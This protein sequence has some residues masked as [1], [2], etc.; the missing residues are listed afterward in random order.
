METKQPVWKLTGHIGDRDVISYGGGFIYEDTTGV[1][2]PEVAY[3]EPASN[4]DWRKKDS[5]AICTIYRFCL[6]RDGTKEWWF[7][8]LDKISSFTGESLESLEHVARVGRL[9]EVALLY[10]DLVSY[11]GAFEFDSYP[12]QLKE[13]DAR[14]KYAA[15]LKAVS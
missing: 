13:K 6:E 4:A 7:K 15:E 14:A 3:F 1:Y 8:S 12:L 11:F 5:D 2:P 9:L 10:S